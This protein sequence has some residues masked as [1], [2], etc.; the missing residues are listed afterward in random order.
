MV[1]VLDF[2]EHLPKEM[3]ADF[4]LQVRERLLDGGQLIIQTP[5]MGSLLASYYR[6]ND[7]THQFGLTESTAVD[8]LMVSGFEG[9]EVD[10]SAAW[11]ATTLFGL[12]RE[13]WLRLLHNT[14]VLVEGSSRP[15]IPTKNLLIRAART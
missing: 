3:A 5:N 2:L 14:V 7:L 15:R 6:H 9:W 13:A 12:V 4:L 11:N 8:L 10:V 1:F